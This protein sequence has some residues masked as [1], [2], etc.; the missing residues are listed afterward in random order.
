MAATTKT[1]GIGAALRR[2]EDLRLITGRG[3]FTDDF[4][5]AG[6]LYIYFLRSPHAHARIIKIDATE[7]LALPGVKSVLTGREIFRLISEFPNP[8]SIR[9][10]VFVPWFKRLVICDFIFHIDTVHTLLPGGIRYGALLFV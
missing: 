3:E 5:E 2:K 8:S 4:R 1:N 10:V 7:A 9:T 6:Q